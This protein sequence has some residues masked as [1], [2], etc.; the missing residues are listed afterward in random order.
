MFNPY[1]EKTL[2]PR[3]EKAINGLPVPYDEDNIEHKTIYGKFIATYGSHYTTKV[4]LGAKRILTT[5]MT[6]QT[7]AELT[8]E[9]VD[10]SSTL[11]VKMQV[12]FLCYTLTCTLNNLIT[13]DGTKHFFFSP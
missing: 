8:R 1:D 11:S 13:D 7:V 5:S 2:D 12:S 9:S 3:F 10:V 6:S 4:V